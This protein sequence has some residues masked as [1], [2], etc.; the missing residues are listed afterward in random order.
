M[1]ATKDNQQGNDCEGDATRQWGD[2]EGT[3]ECSTDCVRLHGVVCQTES[4]G[5]EDGKENGH[6]TT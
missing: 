4:D 2:T 3:V 1:D 6:P 5:D